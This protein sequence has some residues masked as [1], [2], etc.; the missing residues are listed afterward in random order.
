M[1]ARLRLPLVA[2][3]LALLC[4]AQAFAQ[5]STSKPAWPRT[6][7]MSGA[8]VSVFQPQLE[9]WTNGTL[10]A[11]SAVQVQ[12]DGAKTPQY[13]VI[14][15]SAKTDVNKDARI[16]NLSGFQ[17]TRADFPGSR[18]NGKKVVAAFTD[19]VKAKTMLIPLDTV[20]A[21]L[22]AAGSTS[23]AQTVNVRNDAP[24]I[25]V[26]SSSAMLVRV[27]GEPSLNPISGSTLMRI[28]NTPALLL[29]DPASDTL[30]LYLCTT[31]VKSNG[32]NGPWTLVAAPDPG[33]ATAL[34]ASKQKND[35]D[36][37]SDAGQG[38]LQALNSGN[39]PSIYVATAPTELI[40]TEGAPVLKAVPNTSLKWVSNTKSDVLFLPGSST[41]YA[42]VSGRWFSSPSLTNGPW[43]YVAGSALPTE[44][45]KIP[46]SFERSAVLV[47]IPGTAEAR[48]A[49]IANDIAQT[50]TFKIKDL[51]F[52]SS[53]DQD[54]PNFLPIEGTNLKYAVNSRDPIIAVGPTTFYAL[55]D[56]VWFTAIS[57]KGPWT[58]ATS[59]PDAIY[60]IPPSA[61]LYYVTYVRIYKVTSDSITVG[62]TPGYYGSFIGGDGTVVY[63]TGYSYPT[64]VGTDI[65]VYP[66]Y[67]YG[68]A[69]A[70]AWGTAT[71][72][73]LGET[74]AWWGPG[75]G[76]AWGWGGPYYWGGA[77]AW[78][79]AS[80]VYGHW[81]NTYYNGVRGYGYNAA[82]GTYAK[83][84]S[85]STYNTRTGGSS[86]YAAGRAYNP[87]TGNS[88]AGA[89]VEHTNPRTGQTN[90]TSVGRYNDNVY[91][92]RNGNVYRNTGSGWQKYD[93][94]SWN[95]ATTNRSMTQEAQSRW[96]GYDHSAA[97]SRGW[98]ERSWG[99]GSHGGFGGGFRGG[100][101]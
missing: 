97:A 48:E 96:S 90:T 17:V 4:L 11:R 35:A 25:I 49:V 83:G 72:Y 44:F 58:V 43:T 57:P 28:M 75:W 95:A 99:G 10:T 36:L 6:I 2:L 8:T 42:L 63:G 27:H 71:G 40:V 12:K 50:A 70:Y 31:W 18:E 52:S 53:Y 23:S 78:G 32:W 19:H 59:V 7:A 51:H 47:S 56:G 62:Y 88:A 5:Q 100:R 55:K 86:N 45:A 60:T 33:L 13:G 22:A 82:T 98:S 79:A 94:G 92:D 38:L 61:G 93:S 73:L 101:R 34:A 24:R 46:S 77:G 89:S 15:Y 16:V 37:F 30:Y 14:W 21:A 26:S 39:L 64:Y 54:R 69:A 65:V 87:Y 3:A 84:V 68:A 80:N 66:P 29:Q 9:T 91:A 20:Q 85:G 74:S 67:T 76:W 81:G 41:W 1:T